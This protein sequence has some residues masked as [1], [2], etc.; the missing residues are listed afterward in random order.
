MSRLKKFEETDVYEKALERL[1]YIYDTFDNIVVFFSGGKDST[2]VL[3][4]ALKVAKERGDLP[5]K[6]VFCDEEAIPPTTIDYVQRVSEREDVDLYWFCLPIKLRNACSSSEPYWTAWGAEDK[7][8][9]V[10][11]MPEQ[12][13]TEHPNF[14]EGMEWQDF[15]PLIFSTKEMG[16]HIRLTGIRSQE[17]I[18]RYRIIAMKKHDS[19]INSNPDPKTSAYMAHPIY[20]WMAEDVWLAVRKLGWDYNTTYDLY[21]KTHMYGSFNNQRVC[22]PFGEEPIKSL[23]TYSKCFPEMWEKM[24]HRCDGVRTAWRYAGSDLYSTSATKPKDISYKEYLPI[25]LEGYDSKTTKEIKK[26]INTSIRKHKTN[27][28][29]SIKDS[30]AHPI[31]GVSWR[32]I[33][34]LAKRGD[35]KGRA[36]SFY[37]E[38]ALN[39]QKELGITYEEAKKMF[40]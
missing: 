2:A 6:V 31:T 25:I 27:T 37:S 35:L 20:D 18:R 34:S 1:R 36:Q 4:C 32:L 24:S 26:N 11:E 5:L 7:H 8:K 23:D 33:C 9:W 12:A 29:D 17:S 19:Y 15:A 22:Q 16:K 30:E 21:N 28:T 38:E 39:K 13:I 14:K 10:R 40:R 3:N